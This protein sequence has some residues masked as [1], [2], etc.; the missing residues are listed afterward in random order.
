[1]S[2]EDKDMAEEES[3]ED[4]E[5]ATFDSQSSLTPCRPCCPLFELIWTLHVF[6]RP[7]TRSFE[8]GCELSAVP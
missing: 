7:Y 2:D 3:A 5:A 6:F 4:E 1:M 8:Q